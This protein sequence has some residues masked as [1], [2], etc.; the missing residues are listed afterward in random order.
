MGS[1]KNLKKDINNVLADVIDQCQTHL[2]DADDKTGKEIE[3]LIDET[4]ETF[5]NLISKIHDKTVENKSVHF[6]G[7]SEELE[8]KGTEILEKLKKLVS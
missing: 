3:K 4:I 7:V 6:K 2:L 1:I 8:K 5:D